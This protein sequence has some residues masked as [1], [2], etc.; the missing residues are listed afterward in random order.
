M[1]GAGVVEVSNETQHIQKIKKIIHAF[2]L[3]KN[4]ED[5]DRHLVQNYRHFV[6]NI[7]MY[8]R[9]IDFTNQLETANCY[10]FLASSDQAKNCKPEDALALLDAEFGDERIRMFAV[11]KLSFLND[12]YLSLYI[13]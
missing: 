6:I 7:A 2:P 10:E 12:T 3:E 13:P 5:Y 11:T 8:I 9:S 4:H 1:E